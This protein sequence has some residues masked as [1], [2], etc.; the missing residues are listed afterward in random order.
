[1]NADVAGILEQMRE[2]QRQQAEQHKALLTMMAQQQQQQGQGNP[3]ADGNAGLEG[4]PVRE[5]GAK[6]IPKFISCPQSMASLR[7]G[8]TSSSSSSEPSDRSQQVS[9]RR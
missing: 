1:M 5:V 8:R 3:P 6:L 9:K 4:S 2:Q 7:T